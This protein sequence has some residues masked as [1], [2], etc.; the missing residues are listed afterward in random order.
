MALNNNKTFMALYYHPLYKKITFS[1]KYCSQTT[2]AAA[3]L[4]KC[5]NYSVN[6]CE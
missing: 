3:V 5:P 1:L 6:V 2:A 4:S